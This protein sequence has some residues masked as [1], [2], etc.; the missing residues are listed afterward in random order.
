MSKA[1]VFG[2]DARAKL[3][4]G[5]EVIAHAI[6][7]SMGPAGRLSIMRKANT[8]L[9]ASRDGITIAKNS[10]PLADPF[11][12]YGAEMIKNASSATCDAV[13]D[14]TSASSVIGYAL[15]KEGFKLIDENQKPIPFLLRPFK[16]AKKDS[17]VA[18]NIK[19]GIE[20][21]KDKI[22]EQLRLMSKP[23]DTKE[24]ITQIATISANDASIGEMVADA[25]VKMG[26]D[27][28]ISLQES[29]SGKTEMKITNGYQIDRGYL[30]PY[31]VNNEKGECIL[32][33]PLV[34]ITDVPIGNL[35]VIMP[36]LQGCHDKLTGR[37]L[38]LIADTVDSEA[39]ATLV[40][41]HMKH[42]FHSCCVK[43]PGFGDIKKQLMNDLCILTGAQLISNDFG[44]KIE[45]FDVAWLGSAKKVVVTKGTTTIIDGGGTEEAM[46]A[47]IEEIRN[48]IAS[49]E[50]GWDKERQEERLA[51]LVGG[52]CQ[53]M[54]G[55]QTQSE[56]LERMDRFD[57]SL[58]CTRQAIKGGYL[59]GG[60]TAL[61]RA[62]MK[63]FNDP[64]PKEM[65]LG[66][67]IL[68]KAITEPIRRIVENSGNSFKVV[69]GNM[70]NNPEESYGFNAMNESFG[71]LVDDGILDATNVIITALQNA[72]SV[73][74]LML[75]TEALIVEMPEKKE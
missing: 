58:S 44:K 60:G 62:S 57:D 22:V 64:I 63:A 3:L 14:G 8:E 74:G 42:S 52:C 16:A 12:N 45:N 18:V 9:Q 38:L 11:E 32:E 10:L 66:V 19:K 25:L 5:A 50:P 34:L 69:M 73:A 71:N 72:C 67:E 56:A 53:I 29:T 48:G 1:F 7:S 41:N 2:S 61:V 68:K 36:I 59:A 30:S 20:Y 21:G 47:R 75:T 49:S 23:V 24:K 13:G 17:E 27:S 31:F 37:S 39:L 70:A 28:I 65:R 54:V 51:K 33:N 15:I 43:N 35:N 26:N 40:V 55:G 4:N 46:K 6:G